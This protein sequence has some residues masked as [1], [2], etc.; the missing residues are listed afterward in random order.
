MVSTGARVGKFSRGQHWRSEIWRFKILKHL[1]YGLFEDGISNILDFKGSDLSY[2]YDPDHSKTRSFKIRAFLS[3]LQRVM[4][5]IPRFQIPFKVWTNW[6]SISFWTFKIQTSP[7]FRSPL[8]ICFC[9]R[10]RRGANFNLIVL[11]LATSKTELRTFRSRTLR[12][13]TLG[14]QTFRSQL[15]FNSFGTCNQQDWA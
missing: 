14:S 5:K 11:V 10:L 15:Q 8:Y 1:K 7:D 4:T 13:W 3:G 2:S 6:K 12:S 9:N